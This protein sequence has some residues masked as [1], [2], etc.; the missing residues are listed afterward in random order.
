MLCAIENGL[1]YRY[2][3][4]KFE[5]RI[6]NELIHLLES[7]ACPLN[8]LVFRIPSCVKL[9]VRS[10]PLAVCSSLLAYMLSL[11]VQD[12]LLDDWLLRTD[13]ERGQEGLNVAL[14]VF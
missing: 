13:D 1:Q 9:L 2:R 11:G 4:A 10:E 8:L 3:K 5:L 12:S 14:C 6:W 7:T